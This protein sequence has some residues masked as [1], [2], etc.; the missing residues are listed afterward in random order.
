MEAKS[1]ITQWGAHIP[2]IKMLQCPTG[3]T[4]RNSRRGLD[5]EWERVPAEQW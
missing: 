5:D 2:K 3:A 1:D 4:L